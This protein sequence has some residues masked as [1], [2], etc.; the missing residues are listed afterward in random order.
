M[1]DNFVFSA[2]R[3]FVVEAEELEAREELDALRLEIEELRASRRR[4]VL[5][6]DAERRGF[7]RTL[8]DGLQQQLVGLAANLE[9]AARSVES[10]PSSANAV[11]AEMRADLAEALEQTRSLATRIAPP[12]LGNGGLVVALRAAAA[13][14]NVPSRIE[15][16]DDSAFPPQLAAAVYFCFVD[17]LERVPDGSSVA[18]AVREDRGSLVFELTADGDLDAGAVSV[19][20]RVEAL[21]GGLAIRT[22]GNETTWVGTL[23]LSR[24]S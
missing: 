22:E 8:H 17:L 6:A 2:R 16:D 15:V 1:A 9:L 10:D 23:P 4:L 5:S 18:I 19:R 11:L 14:A 3:P 12:L 20:D 13:S 21:G 7:E 24:C